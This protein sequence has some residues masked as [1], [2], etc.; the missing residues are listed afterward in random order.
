MRI[1][2]RLIPGLIIAAVAACGDPE[3]RPMD[4]AMPVE[5]SVFGDQFRTLEKAEGVED[6]LERAAREREEQ[7]RRQGG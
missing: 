6:E 3:Y 5:D 4:E 7:I 2:P 1:L